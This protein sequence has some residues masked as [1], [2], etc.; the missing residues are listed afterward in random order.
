MTRPIKFR[1]WG[2]LAREDYM[3][4]Y[5]VSLENKFGGMMPYVGD[6]DMIC[7]HSLMQFTGLQD[8]KGNDIYEGDI[9][10]ICCD[11]HFSNDCI[12]IETDAMTPIF[13]GVVDMDCGL[14]LWSDPSDK[15][16]IAFSDYYNTASMLEVEIIGNIYESPELIE[17]LV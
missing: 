1:A 5:H 7:D 10:N 17:V 8:A 12:T 11:G 6:N 14:W 15:G 2:H 3:M 9:C 13:K 4:H 16:W